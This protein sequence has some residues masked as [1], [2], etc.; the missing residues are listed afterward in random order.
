[1]H[2]IISYTFWCH[3][4][5]GWLNEE[6][7]SEKVNNINIFIYIYDEGFARFGILWI[8]VIDGNTYETLFAWLAYIII[9]AS[10]FCH[11]GGLAIYFD[12]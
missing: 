3:D 6:T 10:Y 8:L 11:N 5:L 1:M 9:T 4:M 12:E 7:I 2:I